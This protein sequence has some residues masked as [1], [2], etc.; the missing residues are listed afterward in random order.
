MTFES[1]CTATS[2]ASPVKVVMIWP[3]PLKAVSNEPLG[4]SRAAA[5]RAEVGGARGSL[6]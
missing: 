2:Y 3:S 5:N 1:P 6:G 4:F